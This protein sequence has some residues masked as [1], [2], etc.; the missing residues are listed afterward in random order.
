MGA[1]TFDLSALQDDSSI[2][3][4]SKSILKDGKDRGELRFDVN[5][6]PVL[7]ATKNASGIEEIPETSTCLCLSWGY[8]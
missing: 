6:Y 3:G 1:A 2:E 7:T 5:F 4:I 8:C